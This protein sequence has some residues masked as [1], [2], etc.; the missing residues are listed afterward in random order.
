[1]IPIFIIN[2][3]QSFERR[4]SI[5]KQFKSFNQN[6]QTQIIYSFFSAISGRD[7]PNFPL[8]DKYNSRERFKRKGNTMTLGQLGCFASHYLLWQKCVKLN[9]SIIVLEDDIS[10]QDN[11]INI[12]QF[13]FSKE[14]IFEFFWLSPPS[15]S[16][17]SKRNKVLYFDE[18]SNFSI[19]R[20]YKGWENANGYFITPRAAQKLL[21]YCDEWVYDLDISMDRYWENKLEYSAVYPPCI[22]LNN[23]SEISSIPIVKGGGEIERFIFV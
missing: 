11:F 18:K 8:F 12:Y 2:L 4:E 21:S 19:R 9:Q 22:Q 15:K 7:N 1:M 20:Y 17:H 6:Y 16:K 5:D 14:N 3:P 13:C 23:L 10:I